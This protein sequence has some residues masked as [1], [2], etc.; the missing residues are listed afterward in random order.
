MLLYTMTNGYNINQNSNLS[1]PWVQNNTPW[2]TITTTGTVTGPVITYPYTVNSNI[3]NNA[4]LTINGDKIEFKPLNGKHAVIVTNKNT[5]DIDTLYETV[6]L[7][8]EKLMILVE[9]EYILEKHPTLRDAYEAYRLCYALVNPNK[10]E[11]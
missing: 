6:Q 7:L 1:G 9:D 3:T 11:S 5:I 4:T 8:A 10:K 2:T